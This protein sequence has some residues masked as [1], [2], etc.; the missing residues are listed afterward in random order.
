MTEHDRQEARAELARVRRDLAQASGRRRV[1]LILE[2]KDPGAIVRGLPADEL[3]LTVHEVGLGDA[4][5]LVQ[6]A[7]P[8][9]FKVFLDL[10]TWRKDEPETR[11]A[12]PWLRA[13]RAG[14]AADDR[15][16][17]RWTAKLRALD[18]ELLELVLMDTLR[19]HDLEKDPDPEIQGDRFLRTP[20]NRFVV[21]FAVDGTD[22]VAVRGLIDD[23]YAEDPFR[24]TRLL[25]AVRWELR[26]ELVETA[27]RWREGRLADLG[28]PSLEEALSWFA[29]PAATGSA[30]ARA[31][32]PARPPGFFLA[33]VRG[34]ALLERAAAALSEPAR[35]RLQLQL[36]MA[37]NAVL[38]AD[39]VDLEDADAVRGAMAS[40]RALVDLGLEERAAG[41]DP[42]TV[43]AST[44][45]KALFQA[46]FGRLLALRWRAE[47]LLAT[48]KAGTKQ[49]PELDPPLDDVVRALVRR[50]PRYFPG[51]EVPRE[52]WGTPAAGGF[53]PRPFLSA[54]DLARTAA[55]LDEAEKLV[56]AR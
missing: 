53:Q 13:A 32:A 28:H 42:A 35:E 37:A 52:D 41:G 26:T 10:E 56:A 24:A 46:G 20:E 16:G 15:A 17:A 6:L 4:A 43:L 40:A 55:A 31:G 2:A 27:L 25:S 34:G 36:V 3:W 12:L 44:P 18:L 19:I 51:I 9:Q 7:S 14:A 50:R 39:E 5:E 48:G 29:K 30:A 23:F 38:V 11:R 8:Q 1:D 54:E 22:Y 33:S 45:V 49:S 47:R 21:E